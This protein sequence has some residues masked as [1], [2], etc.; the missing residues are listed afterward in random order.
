MNNTIKQP[1]AKDG[2]FANVLTQKNILIG[3]ITLA[4]L[5]FIILTSLFY[6]G[7]DKLSKFLNANEFVKYPIVKIQFHK[8]FEFVPNAE[9]AERRRIEKLI[10]EKS[11]KW[12]EELNDEDVMI[13]FNDPTTYKEEQVQK[14]STLFWEHIW[15]S[16]STNGKN[17]IEGSLQKYCEDKGMWN[18]IGYNPAKKYCF[19]SKAEAIDFV[20]KYIERNCNGM[21]LSQCLCRWNEGNKDDGKPNL[22]CPY[23]DGNLSLAN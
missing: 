17:N 18:E 2:K 9:M 15:K 5:G 23:S 19:S 16:E 21:P 10:N 4:G 20:P 8:P 11:A 1:R 22:T 12:V 3:K 6:T 13:D 7:F 14:Y